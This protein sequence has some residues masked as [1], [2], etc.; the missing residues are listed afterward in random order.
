[1]P[2]QKSNRPQRG[3]AG[4][5]MLLSWLFSFLLVVLAAL[6]MLMTTLCHAGYM[7]SRV[8]ASQYGEKA[9]S[10]MREEFISYGAA[11]GFSEETMTAVLDPVQIEQDLK[12]AVD[13]LYADAPYRYDRPA[14]AEA[15][16]AAMQAEA[17]SRGITLEGQTAASVQVVAEAVRQVYAS[18]TAVPLLGQLFALIGKVRSILLVL[19]P[20]NLVFCAMACILMLRISRHDAMLGA[21]GLV[22]SFGGAGLVSLVIGLAV[23][24][25]L[26]LQ[27]LNLEPLALKDWIVSYVN[28][29][30]GRFL[31][32][33]AV[34]LILAAAL[35]LL[36]RPRRRKSA[37][38]QA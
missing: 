18:Y 2:Q 33:A 37:P 22:F 15:V 20:I 5:T 16:Y 12:D 6:L 28:G 34:Y 7:K 1:M 29:M 17:E 21:R 13:G 26:G 30:F 31:L 8:S 35:A 36:L 9:Y 27:R 10:A 3:V 23:G 24:P 4:W 38:R 25:I 11:T 19:L 32:F 14:V